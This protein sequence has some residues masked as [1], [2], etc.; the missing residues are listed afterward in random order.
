MLHLEGEKRKRVM[1]MA[2]RSSL[3]ARIKRNLQ[4]TDAAAAPL[5]FCCAAAL[6]LTA[7]AGPGEIDSW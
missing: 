3:A 6:T 7:S 1:M 4:L 5:V 2:V